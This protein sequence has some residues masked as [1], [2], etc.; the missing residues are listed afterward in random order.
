M[1]RHHKKREGLNSI[2]GGILLMLRKKIEW[3]TE[4][5]KSCIVIVASSTLF[6]VFYAIMRMQQ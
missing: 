6:E 5:N 4:A 1:Q 2:E 3:S